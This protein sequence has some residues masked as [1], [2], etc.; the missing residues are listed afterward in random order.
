MSADPVRRRR[1]Q[2]IASGAIVALLGFGCASTG[3]PDAFEPVP[4]PPAESAVEVGR[5]P[6]SRAVPAD[7]VRPDAPLRYTVQKGDTLWDIASRFLRDPWYWPEVWHVNPQI[8]NPHRI[9]PGDVIS[10]YWVG[11]RPHIKL[12]PRIRV[13]SLADEPRSIPAA[14][15]SPFLIKP[16]IV[17]A[18]ELAN[19]PYVLGSRD[20]RLIYGTGDTVYIRGADVPTP[21]DEYFVF[22]PG[23]PLHDPATGELLGYQ[24]IQVAEAEVVRAGDPASVLLVG[25]TREVLSGDRL[26][27]AQM[28]ESDLD[29][30]PKSPDSLIEGEVIALFDALSQV[31]RYQAIAINRGLRDG[32][33]RGDVFSIY[34]AGRIL[35]DPHAPGGPEMVTL[36]EERVGLLMVFRTYEKL[37]YGLIMESERPVREGDRIRNP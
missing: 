15:I 27:D 25:A 2:M 28:D 9:Y 13:E 7:V 18:E 8:A 36:P 21:G 24:T 29:F 22:R 4:A 20:R 35:R 5:M 19:A 10:I 31:A 34:E 32:V 26:L 3:T 11:G 16:H 14:A 37:S 33:Q 23:R 30:F 6:E 17:G 1:L 12:E